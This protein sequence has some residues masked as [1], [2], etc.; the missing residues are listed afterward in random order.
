[1]PYGI[2]KI[3]KGLL[4]ARQLIRANKWFAYNRCAHGQSIL[5]L[6][7]FALQANAH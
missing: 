2:K 1:M 3:M 5:P 4:K 7:G 6:L